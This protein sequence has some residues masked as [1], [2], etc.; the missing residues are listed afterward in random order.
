LLGAVLRDLAP[1]DYE[2]PD[3]EYQALLDRVLSIFDREGSESVPIEER[4]AAADA[5]GQAGDPRCSASTS[6]VL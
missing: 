4:I 6:C 1:V 5:L 3:S 2:P